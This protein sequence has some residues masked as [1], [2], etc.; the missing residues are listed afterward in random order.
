MTLEEPPSFL[1]LL[2]VLAVHKTS[3]HKVL[4]S[5]SLLKASSPTLM[6]SDILGIKTL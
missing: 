4:P 2:K 5:F 3:A 1:F 6:I